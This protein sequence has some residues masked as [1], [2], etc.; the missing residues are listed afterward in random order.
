MIICLFNPLNAEMLAYQFFVEQISDILIE[1]E[2]YWM[3]LKI[4]FVI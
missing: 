3:Q 1:N 2:I 4:I